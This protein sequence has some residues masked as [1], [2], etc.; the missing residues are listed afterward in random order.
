[1]E[2]IELNRLLYDE[3]SK[4]NLNLDKINS[5]LSEGADPLGVFNKYGELVYSELIISAIEDDYKNLYEITKMFLDNGMIIKENVLNDRYGDDSI[6]PFWDFAF[7]CDEEGIMTLKLL[8]DKD[9]DI[10]SIETLAG[11][12]YTDYI[13]LEDE[14]DSLKEYKEA[15]IRFEY[16]M[17][18]L[19]L[20]SAYSYVVDNSE[21]IKDLIELDNNSY[22]IS[23]F[24]NFDT[25]YIDVEVK[26]NKNII[27]VFKDNVTNEVMWK[28]ENLK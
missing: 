14:F 22:D 20:C 27:I 3:C 26:N 7:K 15:F 8:L 23:R 12:I 28:M 17:K 19:M 6:N 13:F 21:F 1:M 10:P 16:A 11:H 24:K 25:Y 18:M 4:E 9:L 2:Q 5:L